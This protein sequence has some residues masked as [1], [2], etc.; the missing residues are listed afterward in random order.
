MKYETDLEWMKQLG[1][2]GEDEKKVLMALSRTKYRW[3]K[4]ESL[5]K[6]TGLDERRIDEILSVMIKKQVVRPSMSKAKNIIFGL[7]ERVG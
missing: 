3:R 6:A 1:E 4:R 7:R 2:F 5:A